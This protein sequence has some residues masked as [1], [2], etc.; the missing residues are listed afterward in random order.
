MADDATRRAAIAELARRELARREQANAP[1]QPRRKLSYLEKVRESIGLMQRAGKASAEPLGSMAVNAAIQPIAGLAGLVGIASKALPGDQSGNPARFVEGTQNFLSDL[2]APEPESPDELKVAQ[3]I[4]KPL[5]YLQRGIEYVSEKGGMGSPALSTAIETGINAAPLA[6]GIRTPKPTA[7]VPV[8]R[9]IADTSSRQARRAISEALERDNITPEEAATMLRDLGP[10]ARLADLGENMTDLAR[11]ATAKP[12]PA[13]TRARDF[14][15]ERQAGQQMRLVKTTGLGDVRSFKDAFVRD[16]QGRQSRAAPL[17]REAYEQPLDLSSPQ[18]RALLK[19][20]TMREVLK[21]AAR[22]LADE[23][24]G[25]GH[26]RLMDAA[27][28]SLDDRIGKAVRSGAREEARRLTMLKNDLLAEVDRQ[29]PQFR[30]ARNIYAGEAAMRDASQLGRNVLTRKMDLDEVAGT[31]RNMSDG[32]RVAFQRGA[33]RGLIDKLDGMAN[34]RN[35]AGKLIESPRAREILELAFPRQVFERLMQVAEAEAR[36]S[37][38]RQTVLGGSPTARI[39]EGVKSLENA[40]GFIR[41]LKEGEL[42][43]AFVRSLASGLEK[44]GIGR[45]KDSTLRELARLLFDEYAPPPARI[46]PPA[47]SLRLPQVQPATLAPA[48]LI[49]A[50][51]AALPAPTIAGDRPPPNPRNMLSRLEPHNINS[52]APELPRQ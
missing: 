3:G 16:M 32:E 1:E 38:T 15:E 40:T 4:A 42:Y 31:V 19:R 46:V 49:S 12:G 36:F 35:A 44:L 43:G 52:L 25:G 10:E 7:R 5:G 34:S 9:D 29:V 33:V 27:K 28:R 11:S 24:G 47:G 13:R 18:M 23:G 39:Q 30:E 26:V 8:L 50:P 6:L 22:I 37:R 2:L 51:P 48:S 21:D 14:L 20:P 41:G 45:V 17:Y